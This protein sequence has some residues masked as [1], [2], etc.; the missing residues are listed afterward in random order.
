MAIHQIAKYLL[1]TQTDKS[2]HNKTLN[3]F[4]GMKHKPDRAK[5]IEVFV[6]A[7][8]AGDWN[9]L[10]SDEPSSVMSR[11]GFVIKHMNCPVHWVSKLQT[12][13]TLSTTE[14]E[15][16]ALSHAMRETLPMITFM[17]ETHSCLNLLNFSNDAITKFTVFEDNNGCIELAS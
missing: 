17:N 4:Q 5:R 11:T 1:S 12:W 3:D 7:S 9:K 16:I 6:D 13:I 15:Y 10:F 8:F 14:A 2:R